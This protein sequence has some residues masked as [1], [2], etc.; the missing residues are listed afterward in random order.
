MCSGRS[1]SGCRA[2]GRTRSTRPP[3]WPNAPALAFAQFVML[4]PYPGTVDFELGEALG[5]RRGARRR[6]PVTRHW[7][8][9][10]AQ[11]PK[12]YAPHPVMTPDEIRERTQA[13]WDQFYSLR[14]DLGALAVHADA[15]GAP[16]VCADFEAV[17]ADVRQYGD[18]DRQ[19][20]CQPGESL[21]APDRQAVSA[22]VRRASVACTGSVHCHHPCRP[23][24]APRS[25]A[26][27]ESA[28]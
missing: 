7:L 19:R 6:H 13:V 22:P 16:G 17:P 20:A 14:R 9:P 24:T 18:R 4:T 27:P 25:D 10:Q 8:I 2:I 26:F 28:R 15:A 5:P 23:S 1:S 12:M 3:T 11:R 21:G